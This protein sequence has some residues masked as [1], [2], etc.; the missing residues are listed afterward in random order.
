MR[1]L[2]VLLALFTVLFWVVTPVVVLAEGTDHIGITATGTGTDPITDFVVV[3]SSQDELS[4]Q[5]VETT[6]TWEIPVSADYVIILRRFDGYPE[7]TTD[8]V[9]V[10][11]GTGETFTETITGGIEEI[12][13]SAWTYGGGEWSCAIYYELEVENPMSAYFLFLSL[14]IL[15]GMLTG[16]SGWKRFLPLSMAASISWLALGILL[17]TSPD[18]IGLDTLSST[19]TQVLGFVFLLM[20]FTPILL[21]IKPTT[22][23]HKEGA[24][25]D[26]FGRL[27]K[28]SWSE[29]GSRPSNKAR[30]SE[31]V[32]REYKVMLKRR[33]RR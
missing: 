11:N 9:E 25:R 15:G 27:S 31:I 13:Y 6:G 14:I 33:L 18:T 26:S 7:S 24:V 10:Y 17:M 3:V 23:L 4:G 21:Y 30:R 32:Q 22:T 16:L 1:K 2:W 5:W 12:Y 8:G 20:V 28:V 19:W 29:Q